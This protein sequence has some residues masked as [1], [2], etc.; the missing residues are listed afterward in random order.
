MKKNILEF[1]KNRSVRFSFDFISLKLKKLNRIQT[2]K[3]R[4]KPKK[5]ELN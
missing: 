2:K 5:P 4:T 3:T 1:L